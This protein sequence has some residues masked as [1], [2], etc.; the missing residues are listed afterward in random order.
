MSGGEVGTN[1]DGVGVTI[2]EDTVF[3]IGGA[4]GVIAA[5]G[6]EFKRDFGSHGD[7]DPEVVRGGDDEIAFLSCG[8]GGLREEFGI[9]HGDYE[10]VA[11]RDEGGGIGRAAGFERA[12]GEECGGVGVFEEVAVEL[13]EDGGGVLAGVGF[14]PLLR[15]AAESDARKAFGGVDAG[16]GKEVVE[17]G[18][19]FGEIGR[20]V[21][22]EGDEVGG[23]GI[24][25]KLGDGVFRVEEGEEEGGAVEIG[26]VELRMAEFAAEVLVDMVRGRIGDVGAVPDFEGDLR[27]RFLGLSRGFDGGTEGVERIFD[28][29]GVLEG[30]VV[31][32]IA[33]GVGGGEKLLAFRCVSDGGGELLDG[34]SLGDGFEV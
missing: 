8:D 27:E 34:G 28:G 15:F 18:D 16:F 3:G 23:E 9:V 6:E 22:G 19:E 21:V 5:E 20:L 2:G 4:H 13:F 31:E 25:E 1:G 12:A 11:G 30:K 24:V 29:F 7:M 10:V 32:S 14:E 17:G 33:K 26:A